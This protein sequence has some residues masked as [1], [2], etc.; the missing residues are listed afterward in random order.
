MVVPVHITGA[1]GGADVQL[2]S[3]ASAPE[4]GGFH[5]HTRTTLPLVKEHLICNIQDELQ[6]RS[7]CSEKGKNEPTINKIT[8]PCMSSLQSSHSMN[9]FPGSPQCPTWQS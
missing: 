2:Q 6:N 4:A 5:T 3:P 8:I 9:C 7:A 1:Y